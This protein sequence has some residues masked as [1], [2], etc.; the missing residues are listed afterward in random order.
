VPTLDSKW[1]LIVDD[2][3]PMRELLRLYL[4]S[5]GY[6]IDDCING[7]EAISKVKRNSYDLMIL[8]VMMP[9]MN[10]YEVC[11][12]VRTFS[13]LPI[14][15]LTARNQVVDKVQGLRIGADDYI[16]KPFEQ[17]ELIA[18]IEAIFRREKLLIEK[19]K[20]TDKEVLSFEGLKL[21]KN[22]H[23]VFYLDKEVILTPKEFA[24]LQLFLSNKGRVY[25]RDDILEL[26]WGNSYMGDYRSVDTHIKNLR[27][28]LT[29]SGISGQKV[30]KTVWGVGYKCNEEIHLE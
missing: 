2:E 19:K 11:K 14:I 7:I 25:T 4:M 27:D 21:I 30:I 1:V 18:R 13:S 6:L 28:K 23:Q 10:G 22:D 26:I 20:K 12:E 5:E 17:E 15:M 3:E 8:D 16:T 9:E 24:I 29:D